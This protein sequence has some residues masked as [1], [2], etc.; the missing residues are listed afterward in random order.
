MKK[1]KLIISYYIYAAFL[2]IKKTIKK[3]KDDGF[4]Y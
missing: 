4:I 3:P 1:I 2:K